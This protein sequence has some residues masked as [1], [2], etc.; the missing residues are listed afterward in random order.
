MRLKLG[1][2]SCGLAVFGPISAKVMQNCG[3]GNR[4]VSDLQVCKNLLFLRFRLKK[5]EREPWLN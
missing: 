5:L 4:S 3:P 2:V 1:L